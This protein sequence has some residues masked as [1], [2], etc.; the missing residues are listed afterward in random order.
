VNVRVSEFRSEIAV[1]LRWIRLVVAQ[2][3][4]IWFTI[5]IKSIKLYSSFLT[6]YSE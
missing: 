3:R 2:T 5:Y 6:I 4:S 1:A